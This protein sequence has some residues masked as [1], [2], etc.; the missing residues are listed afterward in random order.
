[1]SLLV[2]AAD[3]GRLTA[4]PEVVPVILVH[5]PGSWKHLPHA[6]RIWHILA[7]NGDPT[8]RAPE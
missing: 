7:G 3:R 1:M 5:R 6:G 2:M 8:M 4:Y